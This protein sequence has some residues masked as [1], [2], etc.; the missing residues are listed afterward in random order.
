M[1]RTYPLGVSCQGPDDT[2]LDVPPRVLARAVATSRA[3]LGAAPDITPWGVR[4]TVV[5][6]ALRT[7][8]LPFVV[9]VAIGKTARYA[10]LVV[11]TLGWLA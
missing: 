10:V 5:A 11:A 6:G 4:L 1:A 9:L 8:L 2:R 7:P 3:E